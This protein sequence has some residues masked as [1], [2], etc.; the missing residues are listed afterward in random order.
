MAAPGASGVQVDSEAGVTTDW[1]GYAIKPYA[2]AYRENRVSLSTASV[3][4][5]TEV[6][7]V[8]NRIVPTKGAVV[9]ARFKVQSGFR[10]LMTL[11]KTDGKPLP[12]GAMVSAEDNSSIVGDDGQVYLSGMPEKGMLT[13]SWGEQADQQ[14][15]VNYQLNAARQEGSILRLSG[16]C[17]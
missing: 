10:V 7:S 17:R 13:A 4:D 12:F 8:V 1:R 2:S 16:V 11:T 14:C 3:D 15:R 6:D 9:M 5:N